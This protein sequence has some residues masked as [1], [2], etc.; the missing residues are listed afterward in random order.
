M[1]G[2]IFMYAIVGCAIV[3]AGVVLYA[4]AMLSR[5]DD[6]AL[7]IL[8]NSL[9]LCVHH[10]PQT[11]VMMI[12]TYGLM[13]FSYQYFTAYIITIPL[14]LYI[15]S[16]IFTR[17]FKS[18]ENTNEQRA[19]EAAEE[20][21][22]AAGLAEKNAAENISENISENIVENIVENITE[23]T[24]ENTAGIEETDFTGGDSTDKTNGMD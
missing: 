3:W 20:K 16:F 5:Y 15:D 14:V 2:T 22:A 11:I 7:R 24:V 13:I 10:L 23:N 21:K 17:I 18:L 1:I 12:A 6:K 8:K 4:F 9:I 19:Q